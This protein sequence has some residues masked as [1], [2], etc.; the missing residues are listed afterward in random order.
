[1][2]EAP[3]DRT[4]ALTLNDAVP[5]EHELR[6]KAGRGRKLLVP[7]LTA[8]LPSPQAFVDLFFELS[9]CSDAIEVGIPFS[10]PIM[11]GPVIQLASQQALEAGV[12]VSGAIKLVAHALRDSSAPAVIMTYFNPVHHMKMD[13]F[14]E[15]LAD[16]GVQGL[17]VP[18]LPYE[19]SGPLH[20]VLESRSIAQIQMVAP[21]TPPARAAMLAKASEGWVYAVSRLGVTGE[22]DELASAAAEVVEMVKPYAHAPVL[23]GIG[24]SNSDQARR[25]AEQ[26]DGV[27]V[28]SAIVKHVISGDLD[29]ALALAKEIRSAL[30]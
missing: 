11:D 29:G 6:T 15:A 1:M 30:E 10:D 27:I 24:I 7:Y 3:V 13:R 18:D 2:P 16:A 23:L 14:A 22:Q 20:K 8:G 9:Q 26:A 5:L 19:E 17:I 28:G 21:S 4:S 12:T 25:A